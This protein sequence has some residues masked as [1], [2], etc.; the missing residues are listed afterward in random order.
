[1]SVMTK[2]KYVLVWLHCSN[3]T[4]F[5]EGRCISAIQEPKE[6]VLE[7]DER[8]YSQFSLTINNNGTK[9]YLEMVPVVLP[10]PHLASAAMMRR[11]QRSIKIDDML[12]KR[13]QRY[14]RL[15]SSPITL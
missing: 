13:F 11:R 6:V 10:F 5:L 1:M 14:F 3:K 2:K 7:L 9:N 15:F 8:Y 12:R 4:V